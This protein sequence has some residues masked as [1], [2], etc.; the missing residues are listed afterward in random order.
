[1]KNKVKKLRE[2]FNRIS[3]KNNKK[4]ICPSL[5][6][7]SLQEV[8]GMNKK[9]IERFNLKNNEKQLHNIRDIDGLK[10]CLGGIFMRDISGYYYHLPIEKMAGLLL[11]RISQGQYFTDGNKRTSVL[12]MIFFLYNNGY[13]IKID[14]DKIEALLWGFASKKNTDKD[15]IQYVEDNLYPKKITP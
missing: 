6:E 3:F 9:E 10:S 15:S 1:M 11:Y 8:I 2:I 7:L 13:N 14:N 4:N 12:C 5:L